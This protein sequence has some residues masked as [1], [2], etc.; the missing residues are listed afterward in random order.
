VAKGSNFEREICRKLDCWW[1]GCK[2]P[3]DSIFWRSTTSGARAT[4]RARKGKRTHGQCGDVTNIHPRGKRLLELI[5]LEL[6]R[7]INKA[8]LTDLVDRSKRSKQT[9]IEEFFQKARDGCKNS[10]SFAWAIIHKRDRRNAMIYYPHRLMKA[11][12][13]AGSFPEPICPFMT[14]DTFFREKRDGKRKLVREIVC[15]TTLSKFLDC[16]TP[17]TIK[18][19][20]KAFKKGERIH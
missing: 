2:D 7:G 19:L 18:A 6:K 13:Q 14:I 3:E 9:I 5:T 10:G 16:V 12:V 8:V 1:E 11:L 4:V 15:V 17:E 20:A